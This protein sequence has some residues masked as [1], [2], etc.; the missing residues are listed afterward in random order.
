M[1]DGTTFALKNLPYS[2]RVGE[3]EVSLWRRSAD[4]SS[5]KM[6]KRETFVSLLKAYGGLYPLCR[7]SF[8]KVY[9]EN[10][11]VNVDSNQLVILDNLNISSV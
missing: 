3:S 10:L 6:K 9:L 7:P 1:A 2:S 4:L 8:H 11:S 5:P